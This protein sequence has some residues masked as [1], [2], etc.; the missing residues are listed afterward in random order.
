MSLIIEEILNLKICI[1]KFSCNSSFHR[2]AR[3][4]LSQ[5]KVSFGHLLSYSEIPNPLSLVHLVTDILVLLLGRFSV[6]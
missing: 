1:F 2:F 5:T 6:S 3:L 4:L